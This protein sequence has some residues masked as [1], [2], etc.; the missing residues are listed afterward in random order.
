AGDRAHRVG[1]VGGRSGSQAVR[2][3]GERRSARRDQARP[4]A[5]H[6][7]GAGRDIRRRAA[8][9]PRQRERSA[10]EKVVSQSGQVTAPSTKAA[11]QEKVAGILAETDKPVRSQDELVDRLASQGVFVTQATLSRDLDELGAV[12][13]RG[14]DGAL[15]YA[16]P[17]DRRDGSPPHPAVVGAEAY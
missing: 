13:L 3:P 6:Q 12:R 15:V 1:R 16:L 10:W 11:R 4:A 2:L 8:R 7:C 5:H 14:P 9:N 17:P